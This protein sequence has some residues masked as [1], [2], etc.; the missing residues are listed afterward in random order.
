MR[1]LFRFKLRHHKRSFEGKS[2]WALGAR[3]GYWPCLKA[4]FIQISMLFW[5]IE[6]WHGYADR[7]QFVAGDA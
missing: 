5:V 1:R 7:E 2:A 4:P 6:I 3:I